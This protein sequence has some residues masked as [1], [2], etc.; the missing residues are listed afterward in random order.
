MIQ[1]QQDVESI[2]C[3]YSILPLSRFVFRRR[4]RLVEQYL[5][6]CVCVAQHTP[7][8]L[9]KLKTRTREREWDQQFSVDDININ[10]ACNIVHLK[11]TI[12]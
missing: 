1:T 11:R 4:R 2:R 12:F 10:Q 7:S 9:R 6:E 3:R 5:I 8:L